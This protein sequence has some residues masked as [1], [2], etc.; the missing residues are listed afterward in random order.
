MENWDIF[1]N[2]ANT[3][4]VKAQ[5]LFIFKEYVRYLNDLYLLHFYKVRVFYVCMMQHNVTLQTEPIWKLLFYR[6]NYKCKNLKRNGGNCERG[7]TFIITG[8]V[9]NDTASIML[10]HKSFNKVCDNC[11]LG[12]NKMCAQLTTLNKISY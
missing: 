12:S 5:L 7:E 2:S 4:F 10:L 3:Q 8:Y 6:C 1:N 9:C 11:N